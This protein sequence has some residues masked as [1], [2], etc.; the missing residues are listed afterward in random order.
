MVKKKKKCSARSHVS[1]YYL[2]CTDGWLETQNL[3][4]ATNFFLSK[5]ATVSLNYLDKLKRHQL[6]TVKRNK[7]K[8][9]PQTKS[10]FSSILD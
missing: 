1:S 7:F 5:F 10:S 6:L 2:L 8:I 9:L 3:L 4:K